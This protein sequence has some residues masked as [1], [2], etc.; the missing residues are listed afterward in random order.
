MLCLYVIA[1]IFIYSILRHNNINIDIIRYMLYE[2]LLFVLLYLLN[3]DY[4]YYVVVLTMSGIMICDFKYYV[5]PDLFHLI[6]L[7]NRLLF[8]YDIDELHGA[9]LNSLIIVSMIYM[10]FITLRYLLNKETIGGGDIKLLFSL[11]I[12]CSYAVNIYCLM[13]SC[14]SALLYMF[15]SKKKMIA[16][17]PFICLGYLLYIISL[18]NNI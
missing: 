15:I 11:G 7:L 4:R 1:G 14:V 12:Y 3:I 5:I 10:T 8:I 2:S 6:L 17:G 9:L 18:Y 13:I 16:F